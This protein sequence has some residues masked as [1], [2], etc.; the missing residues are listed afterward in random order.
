MYLIAGRKSFD[1]P[2]DYRASSPSTQR[3]WRVSDPHT[4]QGSTMVLY[5]PATESA[6]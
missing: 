6:R 1:V 3:I 5:V 4:R 2:Q